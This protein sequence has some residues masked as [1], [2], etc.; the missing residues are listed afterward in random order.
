MNDQDSA[1]TGGDD[2]LQPPE[3]VRMRSLLSGY[4]AAPPAPR[5]AMWRQIEEIRSSAGRVRDASRRDDSRG[6]DAARP[7]RA[8]GIPVSGFGLGWAGRGVFRRRWVWPAAVAASLVLGIFLG[9]DIDLEWTPSRS[10]ESSSLTTTSEGVKDALDAFGRTGLWDEEATRATYRFVVSEYLARTEAYLTRFRLSQAMRVEPDIRAVMDTGVA[11]AEDA[12][13]GASGES[14]RGAWAKG[15]L[16]EARM[17]L[18]S[19]VAEDPEI[20]ELLEDLELV[21]VQ[22]VQIRG[23]GSSTGPNLENRRR[24]DRRLDDQALLDRLRVHIPVGLIELGG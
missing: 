20:R 11:G 7:I 2:R 8:R 15:L 14:T 4:N 23:E 13:P 5:D 21:L 12:R 1:Q 3:I 19:P 16:G 24:L 9:R 10:I 17:L 22:I 6:T 18:G